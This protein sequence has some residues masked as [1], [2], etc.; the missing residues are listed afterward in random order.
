MQ[1]V[2]RLLACTICLGT[3]MAASAPAGADPLTFKCSDARGR[4]TYSNIRCEKQGLKDAGEVA[5]RTTT[6]P[7]GPAQKAPPPR[8]RTAVP[9]AAPD[10]TPPKSDA[11]VDTAPPAQIKPVNPLIERLLK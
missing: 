1:G 2:A 3:L 4:T 6:M 11:D 9:A 5:D 10:T 8:E 7:L